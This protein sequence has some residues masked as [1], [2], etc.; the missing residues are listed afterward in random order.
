MNFETAWFIDEQNR[1][2]KQWQRNQNL[3]T[4]NLFTRLSSMKVLEICN[5][6]VKVLDL[7][8]ALHEF[9]HRP[10][11]NNPTLSQALNREDADLLGKALT[12]IYKSAL[13]G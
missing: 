4:R 6:S 10:D 9:G 2:M 13:Y 8:Y 11:L 12:A 3:L 5:N 1:K 7:P